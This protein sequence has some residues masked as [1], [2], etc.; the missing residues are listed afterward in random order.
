VAQLLFDWQRKDRCC[1]CVT[2]ITGFGPRS[3][4]VKFKEVLEINYGNV[5]L[6]PM[7]GTLH[8]LPW[9]AEGKHRIGE[10]FCEVFWMPPYHDGAHQGACTRYLARAQLERLSEL[11]YRFLSGHEAEFFMYHKDGE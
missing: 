7:P 9:A 4:I 2:V 1:L 8:P 6:R 11:G 5:I 3:E 10:V